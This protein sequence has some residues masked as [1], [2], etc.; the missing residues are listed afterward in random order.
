MRTKTLWTPNDE[1]WKELGERK[2]LP[3]GWTGW[4][5]PDYLHPT[6]GK[7]ARKTRP[8]ARGRPN[9][10]FVAWFPR[11]G[12]MPDEGLMWA[13]ESKRDQLPGFSRTGYFVLTLH[14]RVP[15]DFQ[16]PTRGFC[17]VL[18]KEYLDA[19]DEK[20]QSLFVS[21]IPGQGGS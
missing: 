2:L 1:F 12:K 7:H 16:P 19:L 20:L 8:W 14:V 13:V 17:G 3:D 11:S 15:V 5:S 9:H 18:P 6:T 10:S 21:S 4:V